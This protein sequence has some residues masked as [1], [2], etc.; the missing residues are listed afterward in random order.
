MSPTKFA[1]SIYFHDF[2]SSSCSCFIFEL[3]DTFMR[4]V[5]WRSFCW[6]FNTLN[7]RD[8]ISC[9]L[10]RELLLPPNSTVANVKFMAMQC[11]FYCWKSRHFIS[12]S[13]RLL[14]RLLVPAWTIFLCFIQIETH[15]IHVICTAIA[16]Y[17][18]SFDIRVIILLF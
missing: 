7:A 8:S 1:Q 17:M 15:L 12:T 11:W 14:E 2:S 9:N 16:A 13:N 18:L 10:Y 3:I 6:M 4:V 5:V